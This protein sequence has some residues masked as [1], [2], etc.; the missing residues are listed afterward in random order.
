MKNSKHM[1]ESRV[2]KKNTTR[3]KMMKLLKN[4]A[5]RKK[6]KTL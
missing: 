4:L 3:I 5:K 6:N 2:K 1:N